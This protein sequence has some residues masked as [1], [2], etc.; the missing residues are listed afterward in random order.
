M[1]TGKT[2][3]FVVKLK[4]KIVAAELN[5]ILHV[6]EYQ[7]ILWLE[8]NLWVNENNYTNNYTKD[9]KKYITWSSN[10]VWNINKVF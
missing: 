6:K 1:N 10:I 5:I 3:K 7:C 2:E 9:K 8:I 4:T